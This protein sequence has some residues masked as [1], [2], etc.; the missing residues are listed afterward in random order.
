MVVSFAKL[1]AAGGILVLDV[2][3]TDASRLGADG[4]WRTREA[5]LAD[6]ARLRFSSRPTWRGGWILVEE[7]YEFADASGAAALPRAYTFRMRPWTTA[8][9]EC[10]LRRGGFQRI[11]IQLGRRTTDRLLVTARR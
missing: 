9:L 10:R 8:E 5:E 6:G 2:R 4:T 7:R 1:T 3:E 11:E